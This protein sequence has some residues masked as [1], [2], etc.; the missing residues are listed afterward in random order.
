MDADGSP[1]IVAVS[2]F[3]GDANAGGGSLARIDDSN[4]VIHES[5][6]AER[7]MNGFKRFSQ[8]SIEGV[9]RSIAFRNRVLDLSVEPDFD[10]GLRDESAVGLF[11]DDSI[12]RL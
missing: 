9:D 1:D 7:R 5:H 2:A 3:D 12:G 11:G 6:L 10:G 4:F 8:R